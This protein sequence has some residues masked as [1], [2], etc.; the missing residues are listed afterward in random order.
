MK[1][2]IDSQEHWEDSVN[3]DYD[4]RERFAKFEEEYNRQQPTDDY[5]QGE[6]EMQC[7]LCGEFE[8]FCKCVKT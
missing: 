5:L 2:Y 4:E 3:A 7:N 6:D 1:Q 8:P